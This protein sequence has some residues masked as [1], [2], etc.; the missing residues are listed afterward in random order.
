MVPSWLPHLQ[1][2]D[3]SVRYFN[4]SLILKPDVL[5]CKVGTSAV[6][7]RI[8]T[9]HEKASS[10]IW[11]RIR[12]EWIFVSGIMII[13]KKNY[14]HTVIPLIFLLVFQATKELGTGETEKNVVHS[15]F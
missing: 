15:M 2:V 9:L 11:Y 5:I 1:V 13:I 12:V 14:K 10:D 4:L 6:V 7:V 3:I 8:N